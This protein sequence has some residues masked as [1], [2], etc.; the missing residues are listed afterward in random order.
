L[1]DTFDA[2]AGCAVTDEFAVHVGSVA[3]GGNQVQQRFEERGLALGIV[4][5]NNV[6]AREGFEM[7][8]PKASESVDV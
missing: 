2:E 1:N 7:D 8:V 5:V 4:T 3:L 6:Q